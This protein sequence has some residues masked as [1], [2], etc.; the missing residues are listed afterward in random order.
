MAPTQHTPTQ[1]SLD[2]AHQSA[3][4]APPAPNHRAT[5]LPPQ[6]Q[7]SRRRRRL[8]PFIHS[9]YYVEAQHHEFLRDKAEKLRYITHRLDKN[10]FDVRVF[11]VAASGFL[12]DSYILFVTNTVIPSI[13]YVYMHD[14]PREAAT[15][16]LWMNLSS[17]IGSIVGQ[18]VFGILADI[19]GRTTLYGWELVIVIFA[20]FGFAFTSE[21]ITPVVGTSRVP[22]LDLKSAFYGWRF[23]T[24]CG[25]GAEYPLSAVLTAEWAS[26]NH[27]GQ[28]LAAVFAMQPLGQLFAALAGFFAIGIV[29]HKYDVQSDIRR[30]GGVYTDSSRVAIDRV[31]RGVVLFGAVPSI[32]ALL[33]RFYLPDP[34]RYT[35]E[36]QEDID[37]AVKDTDTAIEKNAFWSWSRTF[38]PWR[39]RLPE[40]GEIE[41]SNCHEP[42]RGTEETADSGSTQP[43]EAEDRAQSLSDLWIYL[44]EERNWTLLFGTCTTWL[45]LDVVF[46]GLGISSPHTLAV[47]WASRQAPDMGIDKVGPWNPDP[48]NPSDTIVDVLKRNSSRL[49]YTSVIGSLFGSVALVLTINW[50]RRKWLLQWSFL[51]I[52]IFLIA[53]G[54]SMRLAFASNKWGVTCA[55]YVICQ[56]LFNYGPNTLT[57]L[58][59]AEIFPTRYRCT[60]H[61]L[62]AASGK[63]GSVLIQVILHQVIRKEF[64]QD[65]FQRKAM[66]LSWTLIAFSG[67]MAL[68]FPVTRI[69]MPDVQRE[70]RNEDKTLIDKSLEDLAPGFE[71]AEWDNQLLGALWFRK[72]W[73]SLLRRRGP[74][75]Q[76]ARSPSSSNVSQISAEPELTH[77]QAVSAG[78]EQSA[79]DH[80]SITSVLQSSQLSSVP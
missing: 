18:I 23:L 71:A 30:T 53:T 73:P 79:A 67:V 8:N 40:E 3:P 77:S 4:P 62:S 80:L 13:M 37:R 32:I 14:D 78:H 24:G 61:G 42:R 75:D 46:Y 41:L 76:V 15:F 1:V 65:A 60:L 74:D 35:L 51:V 26:V 68:G 55:F 70:Q 12:T 43:A 59:P 28:M 69:F 7:H 25:I 36:V 50:V 58:I 31:W 49:I 16:E 29:D 39:K 21:G 2:R 27:R 63:L 44:W 11:L 48:T 52:A 64:D 54:V 20:T 6:Q 5:R 56:V 66:K 9:N 45:L 57:F 33:F 34:G 38:W 72:H 19:Y 22:S 47:V 10:G 17:L